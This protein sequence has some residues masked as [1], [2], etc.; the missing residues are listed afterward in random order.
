MVTHS[1]GNVE[2]MDLEPRPENPPLP[3]TVTDDARQQVT[4]RLQ[5]AVGDGL[6]TLEEFMARLDVVYSAAND[7]ELQSATRDIPAA[8]TVGTSRTIKWLFNIFGDEK[9]AGAW[10]AA[11]SI[12][13]IGIFGDVSLDLRG[14]YVDSA[15]VVI[16]TW[17]IFGD[18]E[19]IVPEGI[20]VD[21]N[22]FTLFGDRKLDLAPV[23]RIPG[24]PRIRLLAFSIFGDAHVRNTKRSDGLRE[25][26]QRMIGREPEPPT[27]KDAS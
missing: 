22:G 20:E 9:R 15:E 7:S 1:G 13:G 23:P 3:S 6:L 11:D 18:A 17:L 25:R 19:L 24:T 8:P 16:R 2:V 4:D 27:N 12:T 26:F 21:L 10:R 5:G 14:A